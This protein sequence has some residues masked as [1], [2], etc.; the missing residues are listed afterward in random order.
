MDKMVELG[1]L[2]INKALYDFIKDEALPHSK[3]T[4]EHFWNA[5]EQTLLKFLFFL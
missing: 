5:F 2:K 1:A 3:I 4:V